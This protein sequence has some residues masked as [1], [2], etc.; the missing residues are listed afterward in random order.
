MLRCVVVF[1]GGLAAVPP[2]VGFASWLFGGMGSKPWFD[3]FLSP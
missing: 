3:E 2:C 1:Y